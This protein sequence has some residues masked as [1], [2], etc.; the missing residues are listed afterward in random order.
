MKKR[1]AE[2]LRKMFQKDGEDSS[3]LTDE[4]VKTNK[5]KQE[6]DVKE[7]VEDK[8]KQEADEFGSGSHKMSSRR[9]LKLPPKPM[10]EIDSNELERK[11]VDV[12]LPKKLSKL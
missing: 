12:I 10:I 4:N 11:I 8:G 5:R 6:G 2:I 9:D 7:T 3:I 1:S